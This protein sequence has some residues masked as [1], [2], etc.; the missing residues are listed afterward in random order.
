MIYPITIVCLHARAMDEIYINRAKP[1]S[2]TFQ[3]YFGVW[4]CGCERERTSLR[5]CVQMVIQTSA[6]NRPR[7]ENFKYCCLY[8]AV[9]FERA[10][11][12]K[13]RFLRPDTCTCVERPR[14]TMCIGFMPAAVEAVR[15]APPTWD[16]YVGSPVGHINWTAAKGY[17]QHNMILRRLYFVQQYNITKQFILVPSPCLLYIPVVCVILYCFWGEGGGIWGH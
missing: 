4:L 7:S 10:T 2:G 1:T 17:R 9:P 3:T 6:N 14:R 8:T 15:I 13:Y 12:R 5:I 16:V 11:H